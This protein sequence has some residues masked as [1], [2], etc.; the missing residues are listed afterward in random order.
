VKAPDHR[1]ELRARLDPFDRDAQLGLEE[2]GRVVTFDTPPFIDSSM[3]AYLGEG[4]RPIDQVARLHL[5]DALAKGLFQAL[6]V[7]VEDFVGTEKLDDFA[8]GQIRGFVE[9]QATVMH[10]GLERLHDQKRT[11]P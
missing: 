8:L 11:A 4:L 1:P 10:V 2:I 6:V 9:N 5:L 7:I 3:C